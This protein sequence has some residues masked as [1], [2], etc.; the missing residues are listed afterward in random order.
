[1][2]INSGANTMTVG[3]F[4]SNPSGAGTLSAG[5]NQTLSVG[6]TLNVGAGQATGTYS[7]IFSVTVTYN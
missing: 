5:G 2:T 4:T 6:A 7:G 3:M 1:V